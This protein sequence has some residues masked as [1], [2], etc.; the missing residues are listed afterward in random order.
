M[1]KKKWPLLF[2]LIFSLFI[3]V[4]IFQHMRPLL[5][6]DSAIYFFVNEL[7]T[8]R[9]PGYPL[10]LEIILSV[11][12]LFSFT[13]SILFWIVFC[14]MFILGLLNCFLIY[15]IT[16]FLTSNRLFSLFI[17]ILYSFN[18][19]VV[20]FEFQIMTETLALT[21]LLATITL[22]IHL[23][24]TNR[25]KYLMFFSG[26]LSVFLL[27]T[28]PT[29]LLWGICLPFIT[30]LYLF[31]FKLKKRIS[32]KAVIV[33]LII[34]IVIN[35]LGIGA[36]SL[37]NKLKYDYFGVSS[38]LSFNL[39]FY[40]SSYF[41]K[42]NPSK[43]QEL[44]RIAEIYIEELKKKG[45]TSAAVYNFNKR[46]QDEMQLTDQEISKAFLKINLKLIKDY[47]L[48]YLKQ[49]PDAIF[50]YYKTYSSNWT[51]RNTKRFLSKK[52]ILTKI[53][54]FFFRFYKTLFNK[55]VIFY[56]II[57]S[58]LLIIPLCKNKEKNHGWVIVYFTIH[59]NCL[60]STV[61]SNAG[62]N[63]LRFRIPVEP[64]I[65][66]TFYSGFFLIAKNIGFFIK[67]KYNIP[68]I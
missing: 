38:V 14:Q 58:P 56:Y 8:V 50:F 15:K 4:Y 5:H 33:G 6:T 64:L 37:R 46:V 32:T 31:I 1:H 2:L 35:I 19:L 7:T 43:N 68:K 10:F 60:I 23:V 65:L 13:K 53:Y 63:I 41:E 57:L 30:M 54:L 61:L 47:P 52:N 67:P 16:E 9:T 29:F 12:D 3:R 22:Y 21:L 11:N 45:S 34:L 17:G 24:K 59:Y 44:N 28:K 20:G 48:L 42:Y 36:W 40:T 26:I 18:F 27:L 49:I 62:M 66:L 39:R 51:G 55:K 25:V